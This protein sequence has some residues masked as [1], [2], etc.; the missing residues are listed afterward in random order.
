MIRRLIILYLN[1]YLKDSS[2]LIRLCDCN[3]TDFTALSAQVKINIKVATLKRIFIFL[4]MKTV[5]QEH[6]SLLFLRL[7]YLFF[8]ISLL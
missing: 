7:S 8:E 6:G 5:Q 2:L 4:V 1:I 3:G